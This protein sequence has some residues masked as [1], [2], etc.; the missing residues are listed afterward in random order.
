MAVALPRMI[1]LRLPVAAGAARHASRRFAS[2]TAFFPRTP[3]AAFR[4]HSRRFVSGGGGGGGD[5]GDLLQH[6][7]RRGE[8]R[9]ASA[10]AAGESDGRD[11]SNPA[12]DDD[13]DDDSGD[14]SAPKPPSPFGG[15]EPNM[16]RLAQLLREAPKREAERKQRELLENA[17]EHTRRSMQG[18]PG[19]KAPLEETTGDVGGNGDGPSGQPA[20]PRGDVNGVAWAS[21]RILALDKRVP[22]WWSFPS[23]PGVRDTAWRDN[24]WQGLVPMPLVVPLVAPPPQLLSVVG[25]QDTRTKLER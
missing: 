15:S 1:V 2:R 20:T 10:A 3:A 6:L 12:H 7:A 16:A 21:A 23:Q 24:S 9:R 4:G 17:R 19:A 13:D 25:L 18:C 22:D 14:P 5:L 11:G 8:E